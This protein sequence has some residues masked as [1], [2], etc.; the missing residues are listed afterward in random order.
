[1]NR[2]EV[3]YIINE[4][5]EEEHGKAV[6]E[7]QLLKECDIDSFGYAMLF[8]GLEAKVLESTGVKVFEPE[9]LSNLKSSDMLVKDLVDL[10][11]AK[12]CM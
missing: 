7:N 4:I 5:I 12:L 10:V 9:I 6:E 8:V 11:E 2:Q 3:L 1:M